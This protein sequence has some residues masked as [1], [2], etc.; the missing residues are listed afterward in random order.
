MSKYKSQNRHINNEMEEF[1]PIQFI[2]SLSLDDF[3][4]YEKTR[5]I[6]IDEHR[7]KFEL[8]VEKQLQYIYE[9][10]VDK[11]PDDIVFNKDQEKSF[12][13]CFSEMIYDNVK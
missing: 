13:S 4:K 7:L 5:N 10:F 2:K 12:S 3:M 6:L 11:F 1:D 9:S 8:K